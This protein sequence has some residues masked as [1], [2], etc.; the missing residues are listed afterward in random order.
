MLD[1]LVARIAV[2]YFI[3]IFTYI[4]YLYG[5]QNGE[6]TH[7]KM[8]RCIDKMARYIDKMASQTRQN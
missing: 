3:Y 8:A 4:L 6:G 2:I 7:A 5:R 1:T